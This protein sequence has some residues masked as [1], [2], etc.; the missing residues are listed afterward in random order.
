MKFPFAVIW[1]TRR[2]VEIL[3]AV[4]RF[5]Y[6]SVVT[7]PRIGEIVTSKKLINVWDHSAVNFVVGCFSF[8]YFINS[9]SFS[10]PCSQRK[11]MPSVYLHHSFGFNSVVGRSNI[12]Y[13]GANFVSIPN[14]VLR[15]CFKSFSFKVKIS[16]LRPTGK[17]Y[18]CWGSDIFFLSEI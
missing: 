5:T 10:S 18:Y 8:R 4:C 13:S 17:F 1:V 15:F 14:L 11:K 16:F 2:R 12:L 9:L 6:K 3:M 7:F